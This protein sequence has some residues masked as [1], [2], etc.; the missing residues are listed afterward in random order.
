MVVKQKVNP[1]QPIC[2]DIE[3]LSGTD[4]QHIDK[5]DL[6]DEVCV[7]TTGD[8][9]QYENTAEV[10]DVQ[11]FHKSKDLAEQPINANPVVQS[12]ETDKECGPRVNTNIKYTLH[13]QLHNDQ[14]VNEESDYKTSLD[15]LDSGVISESYHSV[16]PF[17]ET[18]RTVCASESLECTVSDK[19]EARCDTKLSSNLESRSSIASLSK[20]STS[21]VLETKIEVVSLGVKSDEGFSDS[22]EDHTV[23]SNHTGVS[24]PRIPCRHG[25]A[26]ELWKDLTNFALL[27][28]I[29]I[30][31]YIRYVL[32]SH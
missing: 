24:R 26:G 22:C 15:V 7:N 1:S 17:E 31:P 16:L 18:A 13:T 21:S 9:E 4:V 2:E 11:S 14:R 20:G 28:F 23:K 27:I 3:P 19:V 5:S 12:V 32:N 29:N 6:K 30:R 25:S 8:N 10:R